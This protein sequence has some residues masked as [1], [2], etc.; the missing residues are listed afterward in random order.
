MKR[1]SPLN[2]ILFGIFIISFAFTNVTILNNFFFDG[3]SHN[4]VGIATTNINTTGAEPIL[5]ISNIGD[6]GN[7]GIDISLTQTKGFGYHAYLLDPNTLPEGAYVMWK[8]EDEVWNNLLIEKQEVLNTSGTPRVAFTYDASGNGA[9]ELQVSVYNNNNE[10]I[11]ENIIANN[12]I[13]Y[14]VRSQVTGNNIGFDNYSIN[15]NTR[16]R[17]RSN[18]D[19]IFFIP[20]S[21][22]EIPIAAGGVIMVSPVGI[23]PSTIPVANVELRASQVG[24]YKVAVEQIAMFED[25]L[26]F[27]AL[28]STELIG[29]ND[30]NLLHLKEMDGGGDD[31]IKVDLGE[32]IITTGGLEAKEFENEIINIV[33]TS[34]NPYLMYKSE[35]KLTMAGDE[36]EIGYIKMERD[37]PEYIIITSDFTPV[38]D[39]NPTY[40]I[41]NDGVMVVEM[42]NVNTLSVQDWISSSAFKTKQPGLTKYSNI[43]LFP[44][45]QNMLVNGTSYVGDEIRVVVEVGENIWMTAIELVVD[46]I[47]SLDI[48]N[49]SIYIESDSAEIEEFVKIVGDSLPNRSTRIKRVGNFLYVSGNI[50]TSPFN[51]FGTFS[52]YDLNGNL[53]WTVRLDSVSSLVDFVPVDDQGTA[54]LVVGRSEP[55]STGGSNWQDNESIV[56]RISSAGNIDWVQNFQQNGREYFTH[57]VKVDNQLPPTSPFYIIGAENND[58]INVGSDEKTVVININENGVFNWRQTYRTNSG[59]TELYKHA[60]TLTNGNIALFGNHRESPGGSYRG[61]VMVLDSGG[62]ITTNGNFGFSIDQ[63]IETAVEVNGSTNLYI[64]G[65]DRGTGQAFLGRVSNTGTPI[66]SVRATNQSSFRAIQETAD[67]SLYVLGRSRTTN[68]MQI[69]KNYLSKISIDSTGTPNLVWTRLI[70]DGETAFSEGDFDLLDEGLIAYVDG[71]RDNLV[72]AGDYD[73]LLSI[74]SLDFND[75]L[76]TIDT[77]E[78]LVAYTLMTNTP[79]TAASSSTPTVVNS[80]QGTVLNYICATPCGAS[81]PCIITCPI[82]ITVSTDPGVCTATVNDIPAPTLGGDCSDWSLLSDPLVNIFPVGCNDITWV[83][84]N[85]ITGLQDSCVSQIC[86]QDNES[87]MVTCTD[88]TIDVGNGSISIFPSDVGNATDNCL[89]DL[90]ES[91]DISIFDCDNRNTTTQVIFTVGD[92]AGNTTQCIAN[93]FAKDLV[94]PVITCPAN[95]T[96]AVGE[97]PNDLSITGQATATDICD[98]NPVVS[99]TDQVLQVCPPAGLIERT[100]TATDDCGNTISCIQEIV[101]G[102][103]APKR[104][105]CGEAIVTCFSGNENN[106]NPNG[107]VLGL[108]DIRDHSGFTTAL[109][110]NPLA[111]QMEPSWTAGDMG[112]VFGIAIDKDYNVYLSATTIYKDNYFG[113]TG[114]TGGEI[115]VI[116]GVTGV[117]SLLTRL[118]NSGQGLGNIAYAE[119]HDALYVTNFDDGNIYKIPL[120]APNSFIPYDPFGLDNT[121]LGYAPL[122]QLTWG[123]AYHTMENRIYFGRWNQHSGWSGANDFNVGIGANEIYSVG[124][125]GNGDIDGSTQTTGNDIIVIPQSHIRGASTSNPIPMSN[126]ISD[127]SFSCDGRMLTT[128]KSMLNPDLAGAHNAKVREYVGSHIGGW[129]LSPKQFYIASA[130]GNHSSGGVDYGYESFDPATDPLPPACDSLVWAT[131]DAYQLQNTN[132]LIYGIAGIPIFGN[133]PSPNLNSFYIDANGSLDGDKFEIGDVEI[134]DCGCPS[135]PVVECDSLMV[136]ENYISSQGDSTCCLSF[137]FKNQIGNDITKICVDIKSPDWIFNTGSLMLNNNYTWET[138]TSTTICFEHPSGIPTG[139]LQNVL[140]FCLLETDPSAPIPQELI[141]SWY[142]GE[143]QVVCMDTIYTDCELPNN[144]EPCLT[145][146]NFQVDCSQNSDLEYCVTFDVTNNSGFDAYSLILENLPAGYSFGDCGCGGSN[147]G[148]GGLDFA[149]DFPLGSPLQDGATQT[150]C[151]KIISAY[152]VFNPTNICLN[153]SLEGLVECCSSPTDFCFTLDSCCDPCSSITTSVQTVNDSCCYTLSVDYDCEYDFFTKIEFDIITNGVYFGNH[154]IGD[155]N[156]NVCGLPSLSNVCIEPTTPE[157]L[158]GNYTDLFTFCLTDIDATEIPQQVQVKYWTIGSNGQDSIACD[159]ILTFDCPPSIEDF[160]C[161]FITDEQIECIPDSNK[162]RI[163]VTVQNISNPNFTAE[164]L[165]FWPTGD[166]SPNPVL[167]NP[168]LPNDGSTRT[169]SFCYTPATFP[170]PDGESLIVYRLK[171]MDGDSCCNGNQMIFDT[172]MLPS[173]DTICCLDEAAFISAVE[174]AVTVDVDQDSCKATV[175]INNLPDCDVIT[176]ID[177]G[178]GNS[179]FGSFGN[180]AMPMHMYGSVSGVFN[181]TIHAAEISQNGDTCF[182]HTFV[183]TIDLNCPPIFEC[184]GWESLAFTFSGQTS[185]EVPTNCGNTEPVVFECPNKKDKFSFHGNLNCTS[186]CGG[187]VTWEII[188]NGSM[189]QYLT[190]NAAGWNFGNSHHFDINNI[191]YPPQ[192]FYT[193]KLTGSC[194]MSECSCEVVFEMPECTPSC[195]CENPIIPQDQGIVTTIHTSGCVNTLLPNFK[196]NDECDEVEWSF[197][198]PNSVAFT[199]LGT[200]TGNDPFSYTFASSD[201]AGTSIICMTVRRTLADGTMCEEEQRCQK[202]RIKCGPPTIICNDGLFNNFDFS[203]GAIPGILGMGGASEGWGY[204]VNP[205]ASILD[206]PLA[207]GNYALVVSGNNNQIEACTTKSELLDGLTD[208]VIDI[209]IDDLENEIHPSTELVVRVSVDEQ[210]GTGCEGICQEVA[211]IPL[212]ADLLNSETYPAFNAYFKLDDGL[213]GDDRTFTIHVENSSN[214]PEFTSKVKIGA[215][216]IEP[217]DFDTILVSTNEIFYDPDIQIF[218]NPTDEIIN[219]KFS[220]SLSDDLDYRIVDLLGR[221]LKRGKF[222][223][224]QILHQLQMNGYSEGVYII[225]IGNDELGFYREKIVKHNP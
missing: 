203:Q 212:V 173:C 61:G 214:Q 151:V 213:I 199:T 143:N 35:G 189:T 93:V 187:N 76:C 102:C 174:N 160:P 123:I 3:L 78:S 20:P 28:G 2:F 159:T 153:G 128:E 155:P 54:F 109:V 64:G 113:A 63:F 19:E 175:N 166:Y 71:R 144:E 125:D 184:D 83:Y 57:I 12:E 114:N 53:N 140:E 225:E 6:T 49:A 223:Q 7:D 202:V 136:M 80:N 196:L 131:C 121:S 127:I 42:Q 152:P 43:L 31:G 220:E 90:S 86:V 44:D 119:N 116:D 141:F 224:G 89:G 190:G 178:D 18:D 177:W 218:P 181:I 73:I 39:S 135:K 206:D 154:F 112:E 45:D 46:G 82:S 148:V 134:F 32:K 22:T 92:Q 33:S 124:F 48:A 171:D 101:Q 9:A 208:Y 65:E 132:T 74:S 75:G 38:G 55:I 108:K 77:L 95:I 182:T 91:I 147:Y 41:Y 56:C 5:E 59:D 15:G 27:H 104:F 84:E 146:D 221:T 14:A 207:L 23:G 16:N 21:G 60:I 185:S 198:A 180:G 197:R 195:I 17:S 98:P 210:L 30:G 105:N 68:F 37:S 162:Y 13:A 111:S 193:L 24:H 163:T 130:H 133:Q 149:F 169:V 36:Q 26:F 10:M 62:N 216:C 85:N 192:G 129:S 97:D 118:P 88:I 117:S 8:Y 170:D 110:N 188:E 106:S 87:P 165:S 52:Q 222:E 156:W 168:P 1:S 138:N 200:S 186:D 100:W 161:T 34:N 142:Q 115:F 137:D 164:Q 157:I 194:G 211:R 217:F 126:P 58:P 25:E 79:I 99:Y 67:G 47:S 50:G 51:I 107:F 139:D 179:S 66:W 122:G 209:L 176:Q 70:D 191:P 103:G 4:C 204:A 183:E 201:A 158:S 69:S 96:L 120:I 72:G 215:I 205:G 150:L 172:L 94:A 40:Q 81:D 11:Y 29:S 145:I 219:V 167:L